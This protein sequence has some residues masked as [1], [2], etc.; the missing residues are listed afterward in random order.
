VVDKIVL[1]DKDGINEDRLEVNAERPN[2]YQNLT[3]AE[4][5]RVKR[6]SH[7][8]DRHRVSDKCYSELAKVATLTPA[9]HVK[10]YEAELNEQLGEI[11]QVTIIKPCTIPITFGFET[12]AFGKGW[13]METLGTPWPLAMESLKFHPGPPYPILPFYDLREGHP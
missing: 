10:Q 7:W 1:K 2:T 13:P 9:Y 12:W 11:K 6:S 4:K 5:K 8:K 3:P